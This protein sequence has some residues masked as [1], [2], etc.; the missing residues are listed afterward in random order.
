MVRKVKLVLSEAEKAVIEEKR[1]IKA[2]K[3]RV[4]SQMAFSTILST[5]ADIAREEV[6]HTA[7]ELW[8]SE[9]NVFRDRGEKIKMK[10]FLVN[11]EEVDPF[12]A[13]RYQKEAEWFKDQW[14]RF[15]PGAKTVH[16]RGLHYAISTLAKTP[17]AV[18]LPNGTIYDNT[19]LRWQDLQ[20]YG[21]YA[22]YLELIDPGD[23]EDRRSRE[24]AI[25]EFEQGYRDLWV[26]GST[27]SAFED[28]DFPEFS[29]FP[30]FPAFPELAGL[31]GM[32]G[33]SF[34]L[35]GQQRYGLEVWIEKSTQEKVIQDVCKKHQV[36]SVTAQGEISISA[37][38]E[39]VKRAEKRGNQ[40]TTVILYI[41]DFDPAG[42]SMPV[43]ASRKLEFLRL[44]RQ[45]KVNIRLYPIALTHE[46]CIKYQ[47]PRTPLKKTDERRHQFEDRYGE[48]AT[49]LDAL[50]S[51]HPGVLAELLDES[52]LK[53]RD[54]TIN[55]R[56]WDRKKEIYKELRSLE[57]EVHSMHNTDDIEKDYQEAADALAEI[58]EEHEAYRT[59]H[60]EYRF[61]YEALVEAYKE[62]VMN[63][64]NK[65]YSTYYEPL[66]DNFQS[67][68]HDVVSDLQEKM[69]NVNEYEV[70]EAAEV[71][72]NDN[73]L[74]DSKRDYIPQLA[75]YKNFAGKFA[76]LA[77]EEDDVAS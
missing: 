38:W 74:Y 30:S 66:R 28:F 33:Y 14:L 22:R 68:M 10:D 2:E 65:W 69:P 76:H 16:V 4:R 71:P 73:C 41:S 57:H 63:K 12:N 20:R 3:E 75:I 6:K 25:K 56:I 48:G 31:P 42:Q 32:P 8:R 55:G 58:T 37:M 62:N 77:E 59:A 52:I 61:A 45:S 18:K 7:I 11:A 47:L 17:D 5:M 36:T 70:P 19:D 60:D 35:Q 29:D 50:E 9:L 64:I 67:A 27:Y 43:A 53:F 51:L 24:P 49:E 72:L 1:R 13:H 15:K 39:A 54:N 46:Q 26:T 21:K 23:F 34:L 44:L 40:T